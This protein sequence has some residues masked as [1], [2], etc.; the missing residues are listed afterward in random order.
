MIP[1]TIK[2]FLEEEATVAVAGTSDGENLPHVHRLSGW[3]VE[4]DDQTISCLIPSDYSAGLVARLVENGQF[5]L[6]LEQLGSH[7]TYQFKGDYAGSGAPD[8]NDLELVEQKRE[9]LG[10]MLHELFALPADVG[11]AY[12]LPP[13][14][15]VRFVVREIFL[16][17]PGPGAGQ[18]LFPPEEE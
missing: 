2:A 12:I 17:T 13:E 1:G 11:R 18:R 10:A 16:Q 7:K 15:A 4:E 9:L 5:A 8:A 6:T 14:L 3:R